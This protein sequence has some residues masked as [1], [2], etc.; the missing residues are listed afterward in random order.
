MLKLLVEDLQ[1][2]YSTVQI[3]EDLSDRRSLISLQ[4]A[5]QRWGKEPEYGL[6]VGADLIEQIPQWYAVEELLRLVTLVIFPRPGYPIQAPGL[7]KLTELGG[8]YQ[9]VTGQDS[10]L[11]TPAISSSNYRQTGNSKLIP[12]PVKNY[13]NQQQ[14]Y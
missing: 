13:I 9:L 6:V 7:A 11:I 14:L 4:R 5:Q 10:Q 3:W 2:H 12:I 8:H 1:K